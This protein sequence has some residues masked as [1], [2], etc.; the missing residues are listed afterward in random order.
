VKS[1]RCLETEELGDV[2][3]CGPDDPRQAHARVCPRCAARLAAY[4]DFLAM[5]QGAENPRE[6]DAAAR[7]GAF[8]ED[9][10]LRT[11]PQRKDTS[12]AAQPFGRV[13]G[14]FRPWFAS[15]ASPRRLAPVLGGAL[16]LLAV[17]LALHPWELRTESPL[18]LRGE[19]ATAAMRTGRPLVLANGDI[20]LR[21]APAPGAQSYVVVILSPGFQELGRREAGLDTVATIGPDVLQQPTT[22]PFRGFWQVRAMAKGA[23]IARSRPVPLVWPG[24]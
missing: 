17:V 13:M 23:E 2:L 14:S 7:L 3:R 9:A 18:L 20:E 1:E 10:V 22:Q 12:S 15:L 5:G 8:V 16:A 4:Q 6:E 11:A 24:P 19:D 21:W